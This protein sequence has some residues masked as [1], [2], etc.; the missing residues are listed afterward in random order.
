MVNRFVCLPVHLM[1]SADALV[2]SMKHHLMLESIMNT[3]LISYL[4]CSRQGKHSSVSKNSLKIRFLGRIALGHQGPTRRDIPDPGPGTSQAKTVC[5]VPFSVVLDREWPG[6]LTIWVG[7]S[8]DQ[9]NFMQ[10]N[11]Y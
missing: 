5:K 7:T 6:C 4:W 8:R 3:L 9:K 11:I 10:E 1:A 2:L